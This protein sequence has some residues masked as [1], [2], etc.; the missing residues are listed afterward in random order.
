MSATSFDPLSCSP[1]SEVDPFTHPWEWRPK[2]VLWYPMRLP[3]DISPSPLS[4]APQLPSPASG[5]PLRAVAALP[6]NPKT[7]DR[8][9]LAKAR[10]CR[11]ALREAQAQA[12][13]RDPPPPRCLTKAE[14]R[15]PRPLTAKQRVQ[16]PL[17]ARKTPKRKES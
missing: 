15:G 3:S 7:F 2:E 5:A 9:K 11:E 8:E 6:T 4:P 16:K 12:Q 14:P 17:K 1:Y 13:A 10:A